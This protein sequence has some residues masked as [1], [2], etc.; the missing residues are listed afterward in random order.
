MNS[1]LKVHKYTLTEFM[2]VKKSFANTDWETPFYFPGKENGP[3]P[4]TKL[5]LSE[6]IIA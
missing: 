6:L 4:A 2:Q 5:L 3:Q 1:T